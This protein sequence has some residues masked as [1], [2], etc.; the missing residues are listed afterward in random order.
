MGI[1][2]AEAFTASL[3]PQTRQLKLWADDDY[4]K[5]SENI[6]WRV[7]TFVDDD[8]IFGAHLIVA[9]R[10]EPDEAINAHLESLFIMREPSQRLGIIGETSGFTCQW[11]R[12]ESK[13][14]DARGEWYARARASFIQWYSA[15]HNNDLRWRPDQDYVTHQ[16]DYRW[17]SEWYSQRLTP[18]PPPK[19][20]DI[21]GS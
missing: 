11:L 15:Q 8:Y 9:H 1:A 4:T 10:K 5:F 6:A 21:T 2:L 20:T 13:F 12:N 18:A 7:D 19:F 16:P 17:M 14:F 3:R